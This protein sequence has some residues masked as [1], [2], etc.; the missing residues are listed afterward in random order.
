MKKMLLE[1]IT[2]PF[3]KTKIHLF[4][5]SITHGMG[6]SDF[7]NTGAAIPN[8]SPSVYRNVG[9]K[10]WAAMLAKLFTDHYNK[11]I[12]IPV[13][14]CPNVTLKD[15]GIYAVDGW[16]QLNNTNNVE[17]MSFTFTGDHFSL[18]LFTG[19]ATGIANV[20][21]DDVGQDV[22]TYNATSEK[23]KFDFTGL[24]NTEHEIKVVGTGRKNPSASTTALRFCSVVIPKQVEVVNDGITGHQ[25]FATATL[26]KSNLTEDDNFAIVMAGTNDRTYG[27]AQTMASYDGIYNW[28]KT[29]RPNTKLIFMS[30]NP[31]G[32]PEYEE[33]I[34]V[35]HMEDIDHA[36][37][38][39]AN[40]YNVPF[41]SNYQYLMRYCKFNNVSPYTKIC[42]DGVHPNDLGHWLM[43]MNICEQL[44][45][46]IDSNW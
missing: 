3:V 2:N 17:L 27:N 34:Y 32:T 20:V 31:C 46:S 8:I 37:E 13:K 38:Y 16:Y 23:H 15:G 42:R 4:G 29:N 30:A 12:E 5:D 25:S 36:V 11:D 45:V 35:C 14:I 7:S 22:D 6:S 19:T 39:V 41:I 1:Q 33:P 28:V 18:V 21:I 44:G 43:Y 10:S 24:G 40:K 26:L 9:E